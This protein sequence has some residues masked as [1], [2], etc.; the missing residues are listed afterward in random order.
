M[1]LKKV[2]HQ[3]DPKKKKEVKNGFNPKINSN[4]VAE[5]LSKI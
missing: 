1:D 5:Q 2:K 4:V 3:K